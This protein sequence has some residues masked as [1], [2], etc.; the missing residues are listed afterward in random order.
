MITYGDPSSRGWHQLRSGQI[1]D[2]LWGK[3]A[4]SRDGA[5][6]EQEECAS[7]Q[8]AVMM[9]QPDL[10]STDTID[11]S[12]IL[13]SE[14]LDEEMIALPSNLKMAPRKGLIVDFDVG[15]TITPDR[16]RVIAKL[17]ALDRQ[18]VVAKQA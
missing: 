1:D 10:Q 11:P 2:A 16:K 9:A 15:G 17:P 3:A 8:Y 4:R 5:F 13:R 7:G 12:S 14:V 6:A 18:A